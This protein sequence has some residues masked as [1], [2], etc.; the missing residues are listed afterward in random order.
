MSV[1]RDEPYLDDPFINESVPIRITPA[2]PTTDGP[3]A[4]WLAA[5]PDDTEMPRHL[6]AVGQ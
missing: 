3:T 5:H 4:Q 1:Y 2:P 6:R